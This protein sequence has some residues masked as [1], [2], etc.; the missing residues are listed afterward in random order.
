MSKDEIVVDERQFYE[1]M[2][3]AVKLSVHRRSARKQKHVSKRKG[4]FDHKTGRPGKSK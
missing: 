4:R 2:F 3:E 1:A